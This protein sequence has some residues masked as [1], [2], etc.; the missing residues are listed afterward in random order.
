MKKFHFFVPVVDEN[1]NM[2]VIHW[3]DTLEDFQ[4][5]VNHKREFENILKKDRSVRVM[6]PQTMQAVDIDLSSLM[7]AHDAV[8]LEC[9]F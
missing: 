8:E 6:D 9:F 3:A 2:S 7:E 5:T 4:G 1:Q